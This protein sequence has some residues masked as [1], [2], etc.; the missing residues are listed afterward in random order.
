MA[1]YIE[2]LLAGIFSFIPKENRYYRQKSMQEWY[3]FFYELREQYSVLEMIRFRDRGGVVDS[4][5][6]NQAHSNI[7]GCCM[8]SWG[9]DFDPFEIKTETCKKIFEKY[10][11]AFTPDEIRQIQAIAKKYIERFCITEKESEFGLSR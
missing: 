6:L 8:T 9:Y 5:Q 3:D 2:D 4:R 7:S 1:R 10:R 11:S